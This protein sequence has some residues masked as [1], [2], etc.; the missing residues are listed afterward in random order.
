MSRQCPYSAAVT[1]SKLINET[2]TNHD[3]LRLP[4]SVIV[5]SF[6]HR[7]CFLMNIL[8]RQSDLPFSRK[9]DRKKEKSVVS[10]MHEQPNTV[11]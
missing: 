2:V 3:I 11:G 4:S 6:D 1:N 9:S 10:F 8:G 7:V 5:L